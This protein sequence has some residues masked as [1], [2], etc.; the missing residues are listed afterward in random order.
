MDLF[1][2]GDG[3]WAANS[4]QQLLEDGHHV[5]G[6]VIRTQPT[7]QSLQQLCRQRG[8][9][10]HQPLRVND[11]SFVE[12]VRRAQPV[13]NVSMSYNQIIREPLLRL[14]PRGFINA[15][16][17]KLPKYRG[18]NVI[19]WA[20]INNEP[21]LGLTV[22]YMN[23]GIDT[24]DIILQ[25]MIPIAWEDTYG[26]MLA[27]AQDRFPALLSEAVRL[28][29]RDEAHRIPQ[30][31]NAGTYCP[32]RIEEDEWINWSETS[33]HL[34]NLIRA[35]THPGPGARTRLVEQAV[36]IWKARYDPRWPGYRADA[37]VVVEALPHGGVRVKTGD[38]TLICELVQ[39]EG[40]PP[41]MPRYPVGTRFTS[42]VAHR[43][44]GGV[45]QPAAGWLR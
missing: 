12:V 14:A 42:V 33:L 27:K 31:E 26:S 1:Y 9:R 43:Q 38:S 29:E 35:I 4:L 23:E 30:P 7:D 16:A 44:V 8:L 19:N 2:F 28:I 15:H 24:G 18:R 36:I 25:Q 45:L 39:A 21:E 37:G 6:V 34:Y 20:L 32:A 10:V 41:A 3:V 22:H 40:E 13:L 11:T 5:L 17:G